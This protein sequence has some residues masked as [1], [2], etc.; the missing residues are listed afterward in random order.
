MHF[1]SAQKV[2]L[3][4]PSPGNS[5]ETRAGSSTHESVRQ[6][7]DSDV[8]V[9]DRVQPSYLD[10]GWLDD[11]ISGEQLS[12]VGNTFIMFWYQFMNRIRIHSEINCYVPNYGYYPLIE[13][14]LSLKQ[15]FIQKLKNKYSQNKIIFCIWELA[16]L[17]KI[18]KTR[19]NLSDVAF[20]N[21]G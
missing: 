20:T 8:L 21:R 11:T 18:F 9:I 13:R 3:T 12:T 10:Y 2:N 1:I 6:E 16:F 7:I 19:N 4:S 14:V 15:H 17:L 5:P